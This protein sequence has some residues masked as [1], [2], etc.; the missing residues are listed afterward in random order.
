MTDNGLLITD[1]EDQS[2][3][4]ELGVKPGDRLLSINEQPVRDILDYRFLCA[5]EE[6]LVKVTTQAGEVWELEIEKEYEEDLGLDFGEHSFG[7]TRRC[8]NRCLFCF[9]DQ[10]APKMRET[11][12]IKDDDYRLSFWQGNFVTL[13]NVKEAELQRII[14]QRMGPLFI[15]VHTTNPELRA[16]MLNNRFAGNIMD[17]L[18]KL[19]KAGIEMHTQVVLCP[20]INDG[21]ELKRTIEDLAGLW[22]EIQSMAVVPV[23]VTK[24]RQG[25]YNLRTFTQSEA[26]QVIDLVEGYQQ[27]FLEQWGDS[28]VYASDEFYVMA[29]KPIPPTENYG[30]FPQTENGVGLARLFL[31][32]WDSIKDDLPQRIS[33]NHR[34]TLVTGTSGAAILQQVVDGL[35]Q[36][37]DLQVDLEVVKNQF[38]GESV[39]VTGLL[40]GG[41][42]IKALKNKNLGD[43]VILPSVMLRDGEEVFLDDVTVSDVAD[44]IQTP[45]EVVDGPENLVEVLLGTKA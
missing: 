38:F 34:V 29:G 12:Y 33:S 21:A 32:E 39:T 36:I 27:E 17:Q 25:L 28:F 1:V 3:A 37:K 40:T 2:I 31:D 43:A 19:A 20:D 41:D 22:P 24:Y 26:S 8:H 4:E 11:L 6:L 7:A 13:T 16:R 35:N 45:V 42:I 10:M 14:D 44:K 18:S 9:V 23:G 30:N 15:S 5:A